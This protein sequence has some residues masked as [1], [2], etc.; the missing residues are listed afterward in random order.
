MAIKSKNRA[1]KRLPAIA[2][3]AI[4]NGVVEKVWKG[5]RKNWDG[6]SR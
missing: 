2:V 5:M 3:E 4:R 1:T 6:L